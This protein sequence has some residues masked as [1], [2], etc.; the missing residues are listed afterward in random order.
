MQYEFPPDLRERVQ[1]RMTHGEYL[2]E[3]DLL[4]KALDALED[5]ELQLLQR[6]HEGNRIAMEQSRQGL[7]KPLDLDCVMEQVTK[8]M[9]EHR[10][11]DG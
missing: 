3:D 5:R 2:S 11:G 1:A 9:V 4:R 6:W 8:R 7:S 10:S